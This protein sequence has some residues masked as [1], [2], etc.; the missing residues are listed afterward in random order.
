M[1]LWFVRA[2]AATAVA[3]RLVAGPAL[4][5]PSGQTPPVRVTSCHVVEEPV[6]RRSTTVQETIR[7]SFSVESGPAAD[8]AR[9]TV[10]TPKQVLRD[11]TARGFFSNGVVIADRILAAD[12]PTQERFN[13]LHT[14]ECVPTYVHFVDG[15]SWSASGAQ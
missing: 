15:S 10:L 12:P 3:F 11:F 14:T 1:C 4:A 6:S 13:A 7:V 5:V 2:G 8:L 9:F